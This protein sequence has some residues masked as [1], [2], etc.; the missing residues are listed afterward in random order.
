MKRLAGAMAALCGLF[1]ALFG[2]ATA[3]DITWLTDPGPM[4]ER[5][6][7]WALAG[8][9]LLAADVVLPTPSSLV[10]I[11]HGALFGVFFGTVFSLLGSTAGA[12]IA[13]LAGRRSSGL[14]RRLAAEPPKHRAL[15][16]HRRWGTVAVIVSRPVPVLAESVAVLAGASALGW[17]RFLGAALLGNLPTCALFAAAGAADTGLDPAFHA[18]GLGLLI[19]AVW[20]LG[21][22]GFQKPAEGDL[23]SN[24]MGETGSARP[25][26]PRTRADSTSAHRHRR[27]RPT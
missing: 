6:G 9:A 16:L 1:L 26:A 20:W 13:F 19:A 7:L 4:L 8:I 21:A 18:L 2:V 14:L 23:S 22:R 15:N 17:R 11:A 3:L 27:P 12:A 5:S 24:L 25:E 10:M